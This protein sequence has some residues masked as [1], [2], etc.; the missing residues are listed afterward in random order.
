[1][2]IVSS[3][4]MIT[5]L[6]WQLTAG[7]NTDRWGNRHVAREVTQR[8]AANDYFHYR[9]IPKMLKVAHSL[10]KMLR[11]QILKLFNL[12]LDPKIKIQLICG[13]NRVF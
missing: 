11:L 8:A 3:A 10:R 2:L 9:N 1:M 13:A 6:W 7:W 12:L 5:G 4:V